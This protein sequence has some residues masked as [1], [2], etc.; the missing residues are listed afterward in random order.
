MLQGMKTTIYRY[1][2]LIYIFSRYRA[3]AFWPSIHVT[4]YVISPS[5]E[6]NKV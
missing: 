3:H 4:Q 1:I 5:L 2:I 6:L